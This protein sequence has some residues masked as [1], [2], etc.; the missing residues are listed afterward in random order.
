MLKVVLCVIVSMATA[1]FA[2][3]SNA[4]S[5]GDPAKT[6]PAVISL[7]YQGSRLQRLTDQ[8]TL[9]I[10][11]D[12]TVLM[13]KVYAHSRAYSGT[14]SQAELQSLLGL[15]QKNEFF[16]FDE[17]EVKSKVWSLPV[18]YNELPGHLAST[19]IT[20]R[21]SAGSK[22]V[23]YFG[24]G[25]EPLVKE[26]E[27]LLAIRNRLDQIMSIMKL[28]GQAE[29]QR[30]LALANADLSGKLPNV[31]PL[32]LDDLRSAAIHGDGSAFVRFARVTPES[33]S[34]ISV[35]ISMNESGESSIAIARDDLLSRS[36]NQVR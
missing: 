32:T 34:S 22:T 12:G 4:E 21:G 7:D 2:A 6:G 33:K 18:P 35:S 5:F 27:Q 29:A 25:H 28:G 11:A 1:A 17:S 8:P 26:T 9:S 36:P 16:A 23:S 24:L 3:N 13:P 14:I 30:W 31:A 10:Y 20:V 19:V 15:I